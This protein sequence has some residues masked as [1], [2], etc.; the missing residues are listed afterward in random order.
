MGDRGATTTTEATR[1]RP[2]SQ[3]LAHGASS[4]PWRRL[5]VHHDLSSLPCQKL[6]VSYLELGGGSVR[7]PRARERVGSNT[8]VAIHIQLSVHEIICSCI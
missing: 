7:A 2:I 8:A 4:G 3:R 1:Q 6:M 5:E